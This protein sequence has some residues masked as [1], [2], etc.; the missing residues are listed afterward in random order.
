MT[1]SLNFQLP[2]L[3]APAGNWECAKAAVENG[4]DAIYFGLDKFNARMRSQ[5]FTLADLPELITFLHLRGVK[6]Y[7]TLN[8]LI[9]PLE[10]TEAQKYL[11]TIIAAGVDGVIVQDIGICRLIR[12]LSPD[13]PI[14]ASTQMT[15]TSAMGVKFAQS[16]GCQLVVLARECS[17]KEINKIQQQISEKNITLP[18]EVFIHGALCVAYSGQCLTSEALGGRSANRG[19]CAQAC[20]MPY[21]LIV[22]GKTIDLGDQKY[23][24]SPQDLSGL[25]VLPELVKSGV[26]SLKIEGRLKTPE[27]VANV[28]QVYRKTLD[29]IRPNPLTPFPAR[30]G[31]IRDENTPLSASEMGRGRG[32]DQ[33]NLE[34]AFSRGLYTGW[35]NGINNQELVHARFGK[36]RG[37]HLGEVTRIYQEQVT[38]K[39]AAPVKPGDGIVFDCGHPE[40]PEEGGRIYTVMEKG[41]EVILTFGKGNLNFKKINI[42]D[43]VWKTS[44]PELDKKLRQS[45]SGEHPQ[46][47]RPINIEIYGEVDDQL[48]AIA[49][50]ELGNIVKVESSISLV[51]AHTKPLTTEKLTEQF[52]RLGNT[53][54]HLQTLENHLTGNIMLPVSELNK[55][56]R[57]IVTKLE[58]LR[59]QP[60][61]WTLNHQAKW[62]DLMINKSSVNFADPELIILVRSISQLQAV[63][64]TDIHTIYCELENPNN[65]KQ[66]VQIVRNSGKKVKIFVAPP[67]ITKPGENWILKQVKDSQ[68]DGYLIRN[69][70]QLEYFADENCI[71]DFSL[72]I[73]N[74]LTADYLQTEFNLQR[75][76]ASYDLNIHQLED[77][78]TSYP[79]HFLEV[80]IHQRIPMFHLEHCVFCAFLSEGTDYTNCGRPCEKYDVKMKDRVGTEHIL[81]ADVGCRNTVYNG[82][83][84]TGAE[85]VH[86]L[87]GLGIQYLRIEFLQETPAQVQETIDFYQQLLVG[88]I[89]GSYLWKQL[90]LQN[91]LGVTRGALSNQ[92]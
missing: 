31:G 13:F 88:E 45:Y 69:Y 79:T 25:S 8:T 20:R 67:R 68:A 64:T 19:E 36:K 87:I 16:L 10:I 62:Q 38:I 12:H 92:Y 30:E 18:L 77:L 24:L 46:F 80:T 21:D 53:P 15:I 34:M 9:F 27:Y 86:R 72:N 83:A 89:T 23:L 74:Q 41:Q 85:Y 1:N 61:L 42:G 3:L 90:K 40:L 17:I 54:F 81:K 50:D 71:G 65:Y 57:E 39:I 55:M 59:I 32:Q 49:H 73:A 66:A 43:Q 70:D 26:S 35:F 58:E 51:S 91:Q 7:I 22:D 4:A 63:L 52:S 82:K 44:D 78:I 47:T 75:L 5:N 11:K 33:Y 29:R 60:R 2:E 14:H 28:T 48:I 84:Q 6:G 76:T 37:V 56:R